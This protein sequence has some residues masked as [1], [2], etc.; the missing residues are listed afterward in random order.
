MLLVADAFLILFCELQPTPCLSL[1]LRPALSHF[2]VHP[3][4][5]TQPVLYSFLTLSLPVYTPGS[6]RSTLCSLAPAELVTSRSVYL[7]R[8]RLCLCVSPGLPRR[9]LYLRLSARRGAGY[10]ACGDEATADVL[11]KAHRKA[12][13]GRHLE[14]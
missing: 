5:P 10:G 4:S 2:P 1:Q 13:L 11:S 7:G 14:V 8:Q 12:A 3:L 9:Q 6:H